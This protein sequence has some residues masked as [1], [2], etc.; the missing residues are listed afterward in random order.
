MSYINDIYALPAFDNNFQK[1][2]QLSIELESCITDSITVSDIENTDLLLKLIND[3]IKPELMGYNVLNQV[4]L[5]KVIKALPTTV[6]KEIP[7]KLLLSLSMLV[8]ISA[9]HFLKIDHFKYLNGIKEYQFPQV[10]VKS[11]DSELYF[12]SQ[13]TLK[14]LSKVEVNSLKKLN[15]LKLDSIKTISYLLSQKADILDLSN[16]DKSFMNTICSLN[17][18]YVIIDNNKQLNDLIKLMTIYM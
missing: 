18:Q 16:M 10:I 4:S 12:F 3:S 5:D 8:S 14:K 6:K 15:N 17:L 7:S 1:S 2:L 11:K 9:A 13:S